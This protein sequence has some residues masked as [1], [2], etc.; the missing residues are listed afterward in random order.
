MIRETICENCG[1]EKAP[2]FTACDWCKRPVPNKDEVFYT[3]EESD[4][5]ENR[6]YRK[7]RHFCSRGCLC[8]FYTGGG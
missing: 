4:P 5:Q 6:S 1:Q 7:E 2:R 8:S 3:V